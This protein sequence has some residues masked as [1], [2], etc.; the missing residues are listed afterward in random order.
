[1][2]QFVPATILASL[3][4][5]TACQPTAPPATQ[6]TVAAGPITTAAAFDQVVVG[7]R[8]TLGDNHVTANPDGTLV[9]EFNDAPL[10]GTWE[11][12]DG[13]F[14]RTLTQHATQAATS[15]C[16][17]MALNAD[18]S[19]DVTQAGGRSFTYQRG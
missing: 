2:R 13:R 11:F 14:C 16:Q 12:R 6:G 7:R 15:E 10:L 8:L 19:I 18:G 4:A 3:A 5:L 17:N 1:M 9:G